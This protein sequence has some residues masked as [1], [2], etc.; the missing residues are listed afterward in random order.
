MAT[1]T[2]LVYPDYE[3]IV[4]LY[5]ESI[6]SMYGQAGGSTRGS[7]GSFVEGVL[8]E[9]IVRLAWHEIGG[10]EYRLSIQKRIEPIA[11]E[12]KYVRTLKNEYLRHHIQMNREHYIY[13]VEF[14]RAIEIDN[15]F[16]L[17]IEC[18]AYTDQAMF[19]RCLKEFELIAKLCYPELLF[20]IFQLENGLGGD[21]GEVS[22]P[23]QLGS[24]STHTLLSHTSIASLEIITLLDGKRNSNKPIHKPEYFKEL[25]IEN[26]AVCVSEFRALLEPFHGRNS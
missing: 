26:V 22:N 16:V 5:T 6:Y 15:N 17:G 2:S 8:V 13:N 20:C 25:P 14:D 21:Y 18:K 1:D 9:A 11:I 12:E 23:I 24:T 7:K 10:E 4:D 3:S 19:K